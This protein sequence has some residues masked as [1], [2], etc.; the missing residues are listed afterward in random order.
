MQVKISKRS[1][2]SLAV[3]EIIAD[4]E[5]KGFVARRLRSGAVT[6]GLRYRDRATGRQ[7][8][9]GLGLHG[10]IT[11]DQARVLAKKRVG[12]V[13][14]NR[15]PAGERA[16]IRVAAKQAEATTVNA[17]LDNFLDR[18]VAKVQ[19]RSAKSIAR[20]FDRLVRPR[21]GTL[22]I[23]TLGR[24]DIVDLLDAVEDCSGP[25]KA[26]QT[27]AYL[28][29]AFNWQAVR[30]EHFNSPIVAGM[31]RTKPRERA[32]ARVLDDHELRDL[33]RALDEL[34]NTAPACYPAYIRTLVLT[35]QRRTDVAR[36]AAA[37]ISDTTW[38]IPATRFKTKVE[39]VV[40]LSRATLQLIGPSRKKFI[41][42]TDGGRRAFSGFS[43]SKAELDR[44]IGELRARDGRKAM[45]RWVL[46][47]LRRTARSLMSRAGVPSDIAERVLGHAI[48]GVRAVYDRHDFLVEKADALE[49]LAALVDRIIN[50]AENLVPLATK[51]ALP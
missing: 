29:K 51:K 40:P 49:K 10:A 23:Y 32:R 30:D 7:R 31:A 11:A 8:W 21:I 33:W 38:T 34:G 1:V 4:T 36:M 6:Y 37:E 3:G 14:D 28:R 19:L 15:D 47:D 43:K 9:L 24:R 20:T 25:V 22:S 16:T 5:L 46:H 39:N 27:L 13:A 42:S 41:F 18:Y 48:G 44:K 35:A 50:P 2:D 45:P 12:E 26:D 17:V